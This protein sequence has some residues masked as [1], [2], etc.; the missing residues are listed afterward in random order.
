MTIRLS[1]YHNVIQI[2]KIILL[3]SFLFII[4]YYSAQY[5]I[6]NNL[7]IVFINLSLLTLIYLFLLSTLNCELKMEFVLDNALS[8]LNLCYVC[9]CVCVCKYCMYIVIVTEAA[10]ST[11]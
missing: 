1:R 10:S 5:T 4:I 3:F 9:A 6:L 2:V 11:F 8:C 7:F